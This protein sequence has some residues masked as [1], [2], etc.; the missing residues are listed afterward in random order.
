M[1]WKSE[2]MASICRDAAPPPRRTAAGWNV[3]ITTR[4]SAWNR[5]PRTRL[6]PTGRSRMSRVAKLPSV[7]MMVGSTSRICSFRYGAQDSIS[8]GSGSRLPGGR[9]FRM[10]QMYTSLRWRP[11]SPR[12]VVR[13]CPAAP[14][15]GSPCLSSWNPG[16][17]PMNIRSALGSPTPN[18]TWV[19]PAES[20]HLVQTAASCPSSSIV[21][22]TVM[23]SPY[24]RD[25]GHGLGMPHGA[26]DRCSHGPLHEVLENA[27]W[28]LR[29]AGGEGKDGVPVEDCMRRTYGPG[30]A[31]V[32]RQ[33]QEVGPLLREDGVRG[34]YADGGV[35]ARERSLVGFPGRR[36]RSR[37]DLPLLVH[38]LPERV[39][40]HQCAHDEVTLPGGG[41]SQPALDGALWPVE[42]GHRGPGPGPNVALGD[43]PAGRRARPVPVLGP[44]PGRRISHREVEQ[45]GRR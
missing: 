26:S 45:H 39:H 34:D 19:R 28:S 37:Q 23:S 11:I 31:L 20:R 18:T 43:V 25:A 14:T 21:V 8:S 30:N 24:R 13:S 9:H 35:R 4:P 7:T 5:S 17:S 38:D 12:S 42:V 15:N 33:G 27:L 16:A 44:G 32:G 3:G 2:R 41:G 36:P 6:M 29:L 22:V 40:G 1:A 10:L